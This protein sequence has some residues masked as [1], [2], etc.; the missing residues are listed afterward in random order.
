MRS[1]I[2]VGLLS[3]FVAGPAWADGHMEGPAPRDK[4]ADELPPQTEFFDE[5]DANADGAV[6]SDEYPHSPES[7]RLLDKNKDGKI[8]T[9]EL[10]LPA[11]YRPDPQA[12]KKRKQLRA[13]EQRGDGLA[14]ARDRIVKMLKRMDKDGDD[15]VSRE[16]WTGRAEMFDR[17]D[18]NKDGFLDAKDRAAGGMDKAAF[19]Q[20]VKK[21][22]EALDKN[23]DGA[24]SKDE[25]Q[26]PG[27]LERLDSDGDGTVSFKEFKAVASRM[28]Q[29]ARGDGRNRRGRRLTAQALQRYDRDGDGK[30]ARDEFPGSDRIFAR[31]DANGDG[32]LTSDDIKKS[33]KKQ[34]KAKTDEV[35]T[36]SGSMIK[37]HDKDGDG[38]LNRAEFPGTAEAWKQLDRNGDGWVTKDEVGEK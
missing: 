24:L 20:G 15:R 26:R 11:D 7:F 25:V 27:M 1:A 8:S 19:N 10:G 30:V 6:T 22:F 23:G 12:H 36:E 9:T 18:R 28:R 32:V 16:E 13:R 38:K 21:R 17:V 14:G 33:A 31:L 5:Y 29:G 3:L 35:T 37:T 4:S 34:D 2:A